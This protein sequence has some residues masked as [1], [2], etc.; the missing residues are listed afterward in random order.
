MQFHPNWGVG[1]IAVWVIGVLTARV[2]MIFRRNRVF[3]QKS[4]FQRCAP[5][6]EI[7]LVLLCTAPYLANS[8]Y[9]ERELIEYSV[10]LLFIEVVSWEVYIYVGLVPVNTRH[11]LVFRKSTVGMQILRP[12]GVCLTRSQNAV[13]L[14]RARFEEL[15]CS[16][17]LVTE[18]GQELCIRRLDSGDYMVWQKDVSELHH[19]IEEQRDAAA[20][21]Q[22]E[23]LL[24]AK[25]L[26]ARSEQTAIQE[27]NRI[28]NRLTEEV[29]SQ[30]KLLQGLLKK[31]EKY[32]AGETGFR[33]ICLIGTYIKQR[34]NLRLIEQ[35]EGSIDRSD[36]DRSFRELLDNLAAVKVRGE[37]LWD[38]GELGDPRLALAAYDIFWYLLEQAD[39][40]VEELRGEFLT[41]SQFRIELIPRDGEQTFDV[42]ELKTHCFPGAV[43][44]QS[45]ESGRL[46]VR[47]WEGER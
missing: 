4:L 24:L 28:Y 9:M 26:A 34:C 45:W 6:M 23:S 22:D 5:F 43:L 41:P 12:N 13:E 42:T 44:E 10:L 11:E 32:G 25:E 38:C 36:L 15:R 17:R 21:L 37:I 7:L 1:L 46:L 27:K 20:Q 29:D 16:G 35:S 31:E 18:E 8:F 14:T 33:R 39:F 3:A 30:L 40:R 47:L 2:V 19:L